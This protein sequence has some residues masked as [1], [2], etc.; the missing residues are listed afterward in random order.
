MPNRELFNVIVDLV[1]EEREA[2]P[3]AFEV[4]ENLVFMWAASAAMGQPSHVP[5][6]TAEGTVFDWQPLIRDDLRFQFS[7]IGGPLDSSM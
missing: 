1:V 6:G 7:Y 4:I 5:V 3:E 2:Y